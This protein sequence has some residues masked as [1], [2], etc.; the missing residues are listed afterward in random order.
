MQSLVKRIV[1]GIVST[2]VILI[3][4]AVPAFASAGGKK[5]GG[6][7]SCYVTPDPATVG[8]TY[9]VFGSGLKADEF[10]NVFVADSH[11]TLAFALQADSLGNVTASSYASWPGTYDVSI[12]DNGG[13]KPVYLTSCSFQVN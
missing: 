12:Y 13:R 11:G 9:T 4:V 5:A 7:G 10:V 1:L 8:G 3:L 6:Y 2:L